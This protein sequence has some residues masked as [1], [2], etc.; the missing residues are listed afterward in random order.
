V[1]LTSSVPAPRPKLSNRLFHARSSCDTRACAV[2]LSFVR[3]LGV[4]SIDPFHLT[5]SSFT[6]ILPKQIFRLTRYSSIRC[7]VFFFFFLKG[8]FLSFSFFYNGIWYMVG[9]GVMDFQ[10]V[11]FLNAEL[12]IS[13][14]LLRPGDIVFLV[15][16]WVIRP[17]PVR[18]RTT[19]W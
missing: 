14:F 3:L 2:V 16:L 6:N 8:G 4:S 19:L 15:S 17:S 12:F 7:L 10:P 9:Q 1:T 18:D 5:Y 13:S 11:C